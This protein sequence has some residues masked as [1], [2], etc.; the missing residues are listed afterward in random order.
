MT[1]QIVPVPNLKNREIICLMTSYV[2]SEK[3]LQR[4]QVMIESARKQRD[5]N[6]RLA[7]SIFVS[8]DV[9]P[10]DRD[11]EEWVKSMFQGVGKSQSFV[12]EG[13]RVSQFE[14]YKHLL[15]TQDFSADDW[16]IFSDDDDI[17]SIHRVA[18]MSSE[19]RPLLNDEIV[20]FN[21]VCRVCDAALEATKRGKRW[22]CPAC[23]SCCQEFRCVEDVD[24]AISCGYCVRFHAGLDAVTRKMRDLGEMHTVAVR[25]PV[26]KH[27]I[28]NNS[29]FVQRNRYC[30]MLFLWFLLKQKIALIEV[31]H[32]R[33]LWLYFYRNTIK[34]IPNW[35]EQIDQV[36]EQLEIPILYKGVMDELSIHRRNPRL[37]VDRD[38]AQRQMERARTI[39]CFGCGKVDLTV[40]RRCPAC[41]IA[42]YCDKNCQKAHWNRH[43]QYCKEMSHLKTLLKKQ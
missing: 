32:E 43:K 6:F 42:T 22:V 3:N 27:F 7:V 9:R 36:V 41:Q 13:K 35:T 18:F 39:M 26:L 29:F 1:D 24:A 2:S 20:V 12:F 28:N 25:A 38:L 23:K 11:Y 4:L 37:K 33:R 30:D 19:I 5:Q 31:P 40:R 17:W 34:K 14:G 8:K 15:E 10:R 21:E 16:L